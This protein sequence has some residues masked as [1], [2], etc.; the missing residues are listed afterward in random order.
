MTHAH[1][2][3]FALLLFVLSGIGSTQVAAFPEIPFCPLGG[4]PGW[5]NRIF[6][7]RDDYYPPPA[8]YRAP[9]WQGYPQYSPVYP[10]AYSNRWY[11]APG[12]QGW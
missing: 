7:D 11:P 8:Y 2:L 10:D 9:Y 1:S 5:A 4:P 12:G 3:S 6:D